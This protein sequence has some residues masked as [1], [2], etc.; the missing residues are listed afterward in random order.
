MSLMEDYVKKITSGLLDPEAQDLEAERFYLKSK[1]E[2]TEERLRIIGLA[3][4]ESIK[5][6]T[7][8]A[9]PFMFGFTE[10][11]RHAYSFVEGIKPRALRKPPFWVKDKQ[12]EGV[13]KILTKTRRNIRR[14]VAKL[15]WIMNSE[16]YKYHTDV[17][18]HVI[19]KRVLDCIKGVMEDTIAAY[20]VRAI[21]KKVIK[22]SGVNYEK[23]KNTETIE[24]R[25]V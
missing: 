2:Q 24:D 10:G 9:S 3:I 15:M 12:Q 22:L 1:I 16:Y 14:K 23:V 19:E 25:W 7:F 17:P 13:F 5:S 21:I 4:E 11:M 6:E 18:A 8:N 20:K